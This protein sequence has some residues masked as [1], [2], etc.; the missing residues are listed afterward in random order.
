MPGVRRLLGAAALAFLVCSGLPALPAAAQ[1]SAVSLQLV[2]QTP[3]VLQYH[4]GTL[5]LELLAINGGTTTL[6]NLTLKATFGAKIVTSVDFEQVLT[7]E[8][9]AE[10]IASDE[11]TLH[12]GIEPGVPTPIDMR[13][14]VKRLSGIDQTDS[15]VYP[16]VIEL[17]SETTRLAS[18]ATPMIYLVDRPPEQPLRLT[19]WVQ[20]L[21]PIA[22]GSDGRLVDSSF[23]AAIAEGGVLRAPLDAIGKTTGGRHPSGALDLVLDPLLITQARDVADGYTLSDGT[24]VAQ[25]PSMAEA[26]KFVRRL[27]KVTSHPETLETIAQ[28][29]GDPIVP[30]MLASGLSSQLASE[31]DAAAAVVDSLEPQITGRTAA[32]IVRPRD[33]LLSD[34]ALDNVAGDVVLANDDT[35]DRTPYQDPFASAPAPTVPTASGATMVLPDPTVQD[36]FNRADLFTDPVRGAQIVLGELGVIWKQFPSPGGTTRRGVAI[37]PPST[38][39]PAE[40]PPLL[41]RIGD[42]PFLLP[43]TVSH[44]VKQVNPSNPN[45]QAPL[46]TQDD[47][48]FDAGYVARIT[49]LE[50]S[51]DALGSMLPADDLTARDLRRRL[52]QATAP[53]Y[54][55]DP[56]AGA[57][58]LDSVQAATERAFSAATPAGS[59][60]FT[61]TSTEGT[62]PIRF[63]DP[64]PAPLSIAVE[65]QSANVTFPRGATQSVTLMPGQ[66]TLIEVPVVANGSGESTIVV[67]VRA[68]DGR[69]VSTTLFSVRST[70]VNRI[71]LLVTAGAAAGLVILY[72]RRWVRRR[73][74]AAT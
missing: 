8:L 58:W 30:A 74:I 19:T 59:K 17:W 60:E 37:A 50:G 23:P 24:A 44:L 12:F 32:D 22:F 45:G 47:S 40:W 31:R 51:V 21:A 26:N 33:G 34:E 13:V 16:A 29:Y 1:E 49:E 54:Q 55:F 41:E 46:A 53:P 36:L 6:Q 2:S 35:V 20:L 14:D 70:A 27:G 64:G 63:G 57:P 62:I 5:D 73:R 28:P 7:G 67:I 71:A 66:P 72:A 42:A 61:F 39:P 9:A 48:Q 3:V 43:R 10:P 38:L 25:D 68:P 15:Q 69:E 18:L 65:L 11:K 4:R 56:T 52:F